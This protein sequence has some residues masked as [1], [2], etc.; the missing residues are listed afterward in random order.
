MKFTWRGFLGAAV[1]GALSCLPAVASDQFTYVAVPTGGDPT[2]G[3][4]PGAGCTPVASTTSCNSDGY[5]NWNS[6]GLNNV[7]FTGTISGGTLTA[8]NVYSNA[9]GPG[10]AISG[11]GI[12]GGVTITAKKNDPAANALIGTGGNAELTRFPAPLLRHGVI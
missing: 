9:L 4:I 10:V 8:S 7:P 6:V 1:A 11:A 2:V 3:L 5:A 12:P